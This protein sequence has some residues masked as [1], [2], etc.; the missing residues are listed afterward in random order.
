LV[1]RKGEDEA[2]CA[3]ARRVVLF[4]KGDA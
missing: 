3:L 4:R 2:L 1:G